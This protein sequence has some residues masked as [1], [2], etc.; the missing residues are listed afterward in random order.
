MTTYHIDQISSATA[1][2]QVQVCITQLP[3]ESVLSNEKAK[4]EDATVE[5][6]QSVDN[7]ET[8]HVAM[9]YYIQRMR[10]ENYFE[11]GK[12]KIAGSPHIDFD[13]RCAIAECFNNYT[14]LTDEALAYLLKK[15]STNQVEAKGKHNVEVKCDLCG[16]MVSARKNLP[17]HQKS[18]KCKKRQEAQ[19][20]SEEDREKGKQEKKR[21]LNEKQNI[22][23]PCQFCGHL[24]T[25][26]HLKN[27]QAGAK[28]LKARGGVSNLESG[29]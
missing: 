25:K 23:Y 22:K 1:P 8:A 20:K 24:C 12:W 11:E 19:S 21:K 13:L 5:R 15:C 7:A 28:C 27:H 16:V 14:D 2:N 4:H 3:L 17:R 6:L 18:S 9:C 29:K 10:Q 26:R